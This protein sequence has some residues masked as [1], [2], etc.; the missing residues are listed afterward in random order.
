MSTHERVHTGKKPY[1]CKQ[2]GKSFSQSGTLSHIR[3]STL[4]RSLLN[5][6]GVASVLA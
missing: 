3:E 2:C 5:V 6:H 4:E 1:E